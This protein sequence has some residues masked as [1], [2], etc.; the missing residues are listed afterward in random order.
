V[1]QADDNHVFDHVPT[2]DELIAT[3]GVPATY[4]VHAE[5]TRPSDDRPDVPWRDLLTVVTALAGFGFAARAS[6]NSPLWRPVR[7]AIAG[8]A[9]YFAVTRL[10]R[11]V[12][13][14]IRVYQRYA[15][16]SV[17]DRCVFEPNCSEYMRLAVEKYGAVPGVIKGAQRVARC[18][19]PGGVDLP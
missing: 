5:G 18:R 15:P 4:G 10:D 7:R 17:R 12:V 14:L 3:Y 6:L 16:S 8:T 11:L 13:F 2:R 9:A 19:A 1:A